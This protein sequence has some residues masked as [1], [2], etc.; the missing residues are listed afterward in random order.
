MLWLTA[1]A[2]IFGVTS[3]RHNIRVRPVIP[4]VV[5]LASAGAM[6]L[7]N[8]KWG[9]KQ[10]NYWLVLLMSVATVYYLMQGR[11]RGRVLGSALVLSGCVMELYFIHTYVFVQSDRLHPTAG[12]AISMLIA[13]AAAFVL[14]RLGHW[15][16]SVARLHARPN[17]A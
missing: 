8:V 2:F 6:V 11:L 16:Q 9:A 4:A 14:G 7:L 1:F 3:C 12:A 17:P 10:A 13:V 5:A 15:L